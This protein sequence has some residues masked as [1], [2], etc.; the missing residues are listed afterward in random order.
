M[1]N[2]LLS[3]LRRFRVNSKVFEGA[4]TYDFL[5]PFLLD[6]KER[7]FSIDDL[8]KYYG[9]HN[10]DITDFISQLIQQSLIAEVINIVS[11][12]EFSGKSIKDV[13]ESIP[14]EETIPEIIKPEVVEPEVQITTELKEKSE[15]E[16]S[17]FQL[18]VKVR[19]SIDTDRI[20][21]KL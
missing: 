4:S 13:S 1:N 6:Y 11:F 5:W 9:L 10:D 18:D 7:I 2:I 14:E 17:E 21:V 8:R 12:E 20:V 16:D 15:P 3:K 19:T